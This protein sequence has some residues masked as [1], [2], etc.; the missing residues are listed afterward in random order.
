M[1]VPRRAM[2][3][4]TSLSSTCASP[5]LPSCRPS[6]RTKM[7][8]APTKVRE[9][10]CRRSSIPPA[11]AFATKHA[12]C[13]FRKLNVVVDGKAWR[14]KWTCDEGANDL[15]PP[16]P[17]A[18]RRATAHLAHAML[19][20]DGMGRRCRLARRRMGRRRRRFLE[21]RE[22]AACERR[23]PHGKTNVRGRES[24][25]SPTHLV[26]ARSR[27][28]WLSKRMDVHTLDS[29]ALSKNLLRNRNGKNREWFRGAVVS[30]TSTRT[31]RPTTRV[32]LAN[33]R[34]QRRTKTSEQSA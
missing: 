26:A 15:F 1:G 14:C 8:G 24:C 27:T 25:R 21:T 19:P 31:S 22:L 13:C 17:C 18:L 3:S 23:T 11:V 30:C 29:I 32:P 5:S 28:C 33:V 20:C 34:T 2:N 7:D 10:R 12:C 16:L 9:A 4:S 6:R